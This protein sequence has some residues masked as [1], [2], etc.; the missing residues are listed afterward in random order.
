MMA[1]EGLDNLLEE[2]VR[3]EG[4]NIDM[5]VRSS[6]AWEKK[7]PMAGEI[8]MIFKNA[9]EGQVT[10]SASIWPMMRRTL[11]RS[12]DIEDIPA[13]LIIRG[14]REVNMELKRH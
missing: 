10:I 13:S 9:R 14:G 11:L 1:S 2:F 5:Y 12:F 3:L 8:P 6:R 4:R 7:L